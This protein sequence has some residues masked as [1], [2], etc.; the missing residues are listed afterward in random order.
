MVKA[1]LVVD[2]ELIADVNFASDRI[3]RETN[4][5]T[6]LHRSARI[7]FSSLSFEFDPLWARIVSEQPWSF[8]ICS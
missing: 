5:T 3:G 7:H 1:E 2:G 4:A 8:F 6:A